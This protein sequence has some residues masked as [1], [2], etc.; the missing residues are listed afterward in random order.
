MSKVA[1]VSLGCAK[2]LVD[3]EIMLGQFIDNGW[4]LTQNFSEAELILVNTC[5]FIQTAK[6]ESI[7]HIL[8]MAGYK[9]PKQGRCSKLI[10]TGCL[11]QRYAAEL[12]REIPEV[13]T[14]INLAEIGS[15]IDLMKEPH[16]KVPKKN[17]PPFLNNQ[18]LRRYQVT[19]PHTTYVKIAEGCNHRCSYCAIPLIKGG[20]RSRT[21]EA[22]VKE[23]MALVQAGVREINLIAQDITM[24]GRDLPEN[25]GL[26]DLLIRIIREANPH[27]I[28]LLYAYPTGIDDELLELIATQPTICKYLDIPLQH[29]NSRILRLM[30]RPDSP[31]RIRKLLAKIKSGIPEITLRTTFIVGFPSESPQ[32]FQELLDFIAAGYF[33]HVGVFT[34]SA[35]EGTPAYAYKPKIKESVKQ[36]RRQQLLDIQRPVSARFL[37]NLTGKRFEILIDKVLPDGTIV[38]RTPFLAPEVDGVVYGKNFS[39]NPGEF[40]P[41]KIVRNDEYNLWAEEAG[42]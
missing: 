10:V 22:I 5:G 32:E 13:D 27:W 34:Y 3:T 8:E 38:G 20:F 18:N 16:R 6:E 37:A 11:V 19:L 36:A 24:Y 17:E 9:D 41:G 23:V 1:V 15:V 28:R 21:P 40:R 42:L 35:E 29:I 2:N 33:Q 25:F 14:W 39:G 7:A 12:A 31:E 30:N 26:K 4:E